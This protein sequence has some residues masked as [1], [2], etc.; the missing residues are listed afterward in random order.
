MFLIA[1]DKKQA[2]Y[3]SDFMESVYEKK[4]AFGNSSRKDVI[5]LR[6]WTAY[7]DFKNAFF[8][9]CNSACNIDAGVYLFRT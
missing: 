5:L 8:I 3:I 7:A 6:F 1:A 4:R 9:F 2:R